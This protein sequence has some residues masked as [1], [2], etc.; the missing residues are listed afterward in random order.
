MEWIVDSIMWH[1]TEITYRFWSSKLQSV[2][3][4]LCEGSEEWKSKEKPVLD[5]HL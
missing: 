4:T 3:T 5:L 1:P 2:V